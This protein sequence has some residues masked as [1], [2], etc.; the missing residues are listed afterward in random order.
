MAMTMIDSKYS[1]VYK[2]SHLRSYN[3]GEIVMV[4]V[5]VDRPVDEVLVSY[6]LDFDYKATGLRLGMASS[7]IREIVNANGKALGDLQKSRQLRVKVD[8]DY[9]LSALKELNEG[10][11]SEIYNDDGSLKPLSQWPAVFRKGVRSLDVNERV[12][13][14]GKLVGRV[15]KVKLP[16]KLKTLELMGKHVAVKAFSEQVDVVDTSTIA[17]LIATRALRLNSIEVSGEDNG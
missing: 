15:V 16:D 12:D 10:D 9:I 2:Y 5:V 4:G 17:S 11:I 8:A 3:I 6:L 14:S 13:E 1:V 7:A